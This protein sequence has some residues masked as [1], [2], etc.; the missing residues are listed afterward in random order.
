M[1]VVFILTV[2]VLLS[3]C[4]QQLQSILPTSFL[5]LLGY[6][7]D[8]SEPEPDPF[9]GSGIET[10]LRRANTSPLLPVS[11]QNENTAFLLLQPFT[12]SQ[13]VN[14]GYIQEAD[15]N[16]GYNVALTVSFMPEENRPEVTANLSSLAS[17]VPVGSPSGTSGRQRAWVKL[18]PY[19]TLHYLSASNYLGADTTGGGLNRENSDYIEYQ[20]VSSIVPG[21]AEAGQDPPDEEVIRVH[22]VLLN[23]LAAFP[24]HERFAYDTTRGNLNPE[25]RDSYLYNVGYG[26]WQDEDRAAE[27][28][29]TEGIARYIGVFLGRQRV[30]VTR[31]SEEVPVLVARESKTPVI[32]FFLDFASADSVRFRIENAELRII[33]NGYVGDVIVDTTGAGD[34]GNNS[35]TARIERVAIDISALD[36]TTNTA[37]AERLL[38]NQLDDSDETN[39]LQ[40]FFFDGDEPSSVLAGYLYGLGDLEGRRF[41]LGGGQVIANIEFYIDGVFIAEE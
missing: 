39:F 19:A 1:K 35:L 14:A 9:E 4:Q 36:T 34:L 31:V 32:T 21:Q 24:A 38:F 13:L 40:G 2:T 8:D 22:M 20:A 23:D 18:S 10:A 17:R 37:F 6:V 3:G 16:E 29:P 7:I 33:S 28:V 25:T 15:I 26:I 41:N 12:F 30:S 11:N 27:S 5:D